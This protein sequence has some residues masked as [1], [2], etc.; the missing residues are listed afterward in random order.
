MINTRIREIKKYLP[1]H[2]KKRKIKKIN[3]SVILKKNSKVNNNK[4]TENMGCII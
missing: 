2:Q 4:I 3:K 1:N